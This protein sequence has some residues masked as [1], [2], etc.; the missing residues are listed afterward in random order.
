M[1]TPSSQ[2]RGTFKATYSITSPVYL[3]AEDNTVEGSDPYLT[4]VHGTLYFDPDEG[5][6]PQEAATLQAC[7]LDLGCAYGEDGFPAESLFDVMDADSDELA[8][9]YNAL[10][11]P[12]G[13]PRKAF[14]D[15][16][17]SLGM[18]SV[19]S[20]VKAIIVKPEFR[21]HG[22][23]L[24]FFWDFI[25]H[26]AK[27]DSSGVVVCKPAPIHH[28]ENQKAGTFPKMTWKQAQMK[29]QGH[30]ERLGLAPIGKT[31]I[32]VLDLTCKLKSWAEVGGERTGV[33]AKP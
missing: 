12:N 2:R 14:E 24:Y 32:Y 19:M 27:L 9:A 1:E 16:C 7:L 20:F 22:L 4:D 11:T 17:D 26:I 13:K 29:L 33:P 28:D 10:F 8:E 15:A 25:R 21:G 18:A 31:G 30:W 3:D 23:G 6:A 5:G